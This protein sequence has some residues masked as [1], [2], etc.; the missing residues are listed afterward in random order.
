MRDDPIARLKD[1][2]KQSGWGVSRRRDLSFDQPELPSLS[3]C[4]A[5]RRMR[6]RH[7]RAARISTS[8]CSSHSCGMSR[9]LERV[10]GAARQIQLSHR[11]CKG[12]LW[13]EYLRRPD[14]QTAGR[15]GAA[16]AGR[17]LDRRL[18]RAAG[19][20]PAACACVGTYEHEECDYLIAEALAVPLGNGDA[21]PVSVL[22]ATYFT[23]RHKNRGLGEILRQRGAGLVAQAPP[24]GR[25]SCARCRSPRARS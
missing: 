21:P 16:R 4:G 19:S 1:R 15:R 2:I 12:P 23:P 8:G 25:N 3:I 17:T 14:R 20:A 22:S 13:C 10:V 18:R 11:A 6:C 7:C 9:C 24:C 5:P